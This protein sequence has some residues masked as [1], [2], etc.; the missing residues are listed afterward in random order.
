MCTL[1]HAGGVAR[2]RRCAVGEEWRAL[3]EVRRAA[4]GTRSLT[5]GGAV[6]NTMR[7]G[8]AEGSTGKPLA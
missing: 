1:V 6:G 2:G 4:A 5:C 3:C 8:N 7:G